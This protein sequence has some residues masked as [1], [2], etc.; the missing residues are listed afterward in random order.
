M[1]NYPPKIEGIQVHSMDDFI[2]KIMELR[3]PSLA[4]PEEL[5][6][7]MNDSIKCHFESIE[8]LGVTWD[9]IIGHEDAKELLRSAI[10]DA[11]DHRELY[12]LY[13][14]KPA[15]GVCLWGPP[16]NG[17]TMLAK[18]VAHTVGAKVIG[19]IKTSALIDKYVGETEKHITGLF[20]YARQYYKRHGKQLILFFD[21]AD[22]IVPQRGEWNYRN[23]M[24]NQ[25]LAELDGLRSNGAFVILATNRPQD[26]DE[27]VL[28]DGRIDRKIYVGRPDYSACLKIVRGTVSGML[29]A[30]ADDLVVTAVE[31]LFDPSYV[32]EKGMKVKIK[33]RKTTTH[34][35]D[36]V[37][38]DIVSGA[39][40]AGI[41]PRAKRI[42]FARDRDN[43]SRTGVGVEDVMAAVRQIYE[44]NRGIPHP[45]AFQEFIERLQKEEQE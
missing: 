22:V 8:D 42:A 32:L 6:D 31:C 3:A 43:N 10:L 30:P 2:G 1:A 45:A 37:L 25:F 33:E 41:M 20:D 5:G 12:N 4:D 27:A 35:L 26:L 19:V 36:F 21:E 16:G 44:E 34:H 11:Q 7:K 23:S 39:M 29:G 24:T 28:R 13:D 17:K 18:A 15:K 40:A 38:S 9:D 14:L